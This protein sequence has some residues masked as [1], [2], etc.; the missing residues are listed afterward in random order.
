MQDAIII[1]AGFSGLAAAHALKE[2]GIEE[3]TVLEA[4]GRVGGRTKPGEVGGVQVDFGGMWLG[5]TQERLASFAERYQMRTYPTPL[6]GKAI[7]RV[8]GKEHQGVREDPNGLFNLWDGV[9]DMMARRQLDK[10]MA[11][12]DCDAPWTHPDAARLDTMTVDSWIEKTFRSARLRAFYRLL[13]YALFCAEAS[14]ISML[15]FLHYIKA[16]DGLEIL[17][18]SDEGGA[19]NLLFHG[20]VHQIARKMG[21]E[22]GDRL[23]LGAPVS[24]IVWDDNG[25]TVHTPAG[26]FE[27]RQAI[28]SIPPT[29]VPRIAFHPALPQPKT[30]FHARVAMGSAIKFWVAYETPFWRE[31]GFN[32]TIV[33]EDNPATPA[34]DASPPGQPL[35]IMAGFFDG[36]HAIQQ[37][38]IGMEARRRIV[39]EMLA[40]HYGE[41]ALHPIDYQ[42]TD[43]TQEEWSSG[44]YGAYAPPGV[45]SHYGEWLKKPIGPLHW[46]GTETA[47]RWTGYID[48]A[49]RSGERAAG[50]VAD[51]V[52]AA[53]AA[54]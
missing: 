4:R 41:K 2:K 38:D 17:L 46:A 3:F 31:Q 20:G 1:G 50:E 36:D 52:A 32:G 7:Y 27:A 13:C 24:K 43:W 47:E 9:N 40:E 34:F 6:E 21:E 28:I 12:L 15:F 54:A 44:C 19:Q 26:A 18:S 30:A 37:S 5:P 45:L 53:R 51:A 48:G 35:G 29:L 33:R 42:D 49:I 10:L 14:Q 25:V 22:L 23:K 39:I 8:D 16:G 11:P